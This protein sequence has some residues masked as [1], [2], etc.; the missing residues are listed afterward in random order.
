MVSYRCAACHLPIAGPSVGPNFGKFA[1]H[2]VTLTDGRRVVVDVRFLRRGLVRPDRYV[3]RG[4]D[5]APMLQAV[6]HLNLGKDPPRVAALAA[7]IE[8]MGPE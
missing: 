4:Y 6:R 2:T 5:P 8:Q 1:G 7:F 3:I